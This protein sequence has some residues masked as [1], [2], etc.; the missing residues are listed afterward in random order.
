MRSGQKDITWTGLDDRNPLSL[1]RCVGAGRNGRVRYEVRRVEGDGVCDILLERMSPPT[2]S[3]PINFARTYE[4]PANQ[5]NLRQNC[6]I[7]GTGRHAVRTVASIQNSSSEKRA[8]ASG[9]TG[10]VQ[11]DN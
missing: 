4:S 1:L 7:S 3:G 2:G 10:R 5:K 8:A 11:K 9:T 6:D